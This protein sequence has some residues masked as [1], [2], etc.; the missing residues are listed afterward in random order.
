ML[1]ALPQLTP[2]LRLACV[3]CFQAPMGPAQ[4]SGGR[5]YDCSTRAQ[6]FP[7]RASETPKDQ[8]PV[9]F[10]SVPVQTVSILPLAGSSVASPLLPSICSANGALPEGSQSSQL[11]EAFR[12][13]VR[14]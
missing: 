12:L 6:V 8:P 9:E 2:A 13:G 10:D 1:S 3:T 7:S 11:A 14:L 4:T 5:T